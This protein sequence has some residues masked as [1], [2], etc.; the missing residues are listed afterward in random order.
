MSTTIKLQAG[1]VQVIENGRVTLIN[2]PDDAERRLVNR[3]T[4]NQFCRE[5]GVP[6]MY[7]EVGRAS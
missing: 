5:R 7:P 2:R 6:V 3:L 4:V 1:R